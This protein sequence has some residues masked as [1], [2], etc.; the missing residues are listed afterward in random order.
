MPF[1]IVL[2]K[3][4]L[5]QWKP[6]EHNGTFRGNNLAFVTAKAA[7][8]HYWADDKFVKTVVKKGQYIKD[9]LE[10]IVEKYGNGN[11]T[12]RGRGMFQGI[13]CVNGDVAS[14]ITRKAFQKGLIIETSGADDQVV[15]LLCP[16]TISEDNLKRGIDILEQSIKEVCEK[17]DD[18]PAEQDYFDADYTPQLKNVS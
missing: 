4:E 7:L 11:F 16:L 6:G 1:A 2:M 8:D 15:K 13:N 12:T 9:R 17:A 14:L 18:I 3:P 5:D 10:N